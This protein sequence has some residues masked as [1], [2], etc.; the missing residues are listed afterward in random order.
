MSKSNRLRNGI[1]VWFGVAVFLVYGW[2]IV[3]LVQ[4]QQTGT[5][6]IE[7]ESAEDQKHRD[8]AIANCAG[9]P[10]IE[11]VVCVADAYA[12]E[13]EARRSHEDLQAQQDSARGTF[14]MIIVGGSQ[15]VLSVVGIFLVAQTLDETRKANAGSA[16]S[17][18]AAHRSASAASDAASATREGAE[19]ARIAHLRDTRPWLTVGCSSAQATFSEKQ[20]AIGGEFTFKN[21]G[22][23]P[24][25]QVR[26]FAK[27]YSLKGEHDFGA[28]VRNFI[29]AELEPRLEDSGDVV[30]AQDG[31]DRG[32]H[33]P[34]IDLTETL[35]VE[36]SDPS[37]PD[38]E[39]LEF[40]IIFGVTYK[41]LYEDRTFCSAKAY[42]VTAD[43]RTGGKPLQH[44]PNAQFYRL[45]GD[46]MS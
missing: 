16:A 19:R 24:A 29:E 15:A 42:S 37:I 31:W 3:D 39:R 25:V 20:I 17:A 33:V 5:A 46:M 18:S 28:D 2:A 36:V 11:L 7:R 23:S 21:I 12:A 35:P 34:S 27:A 44:A 26:S 4:R 41:S 10:S 14:W 30:V 13:R 1:V 40:M 9:E 8:Y 22:R 45:P 43:H 6:R 32:N 38:L